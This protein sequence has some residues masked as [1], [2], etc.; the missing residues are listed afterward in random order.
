MVLGETWPLE[1]M[2][3]FILILIRVAAILY[4]MPVLGTRNI[5]A[6]SKI[7]LSMMISFLLIPLVKID[8]QSFPQE[9]LYF[10][11]FL[12]KEIILGMVLGISIKFIFA[13]VQAGG[14]LAGFNMGFTMAQI[15]DPQSGFQE[16][17]LTQL[18][19][20]LSMLIFLAIDGHHWFIR[21][22][23][24]SLEIVPPGGFFLREPLGEHLV[25]LSGGIL[26]IAVKIAAP[27]LVA[28]FLVQMGLGILAKAAPQINIMMTS[29]PLIIAAGLLIL[30]LSTLL[31][32]G[33][34]KEIFMDG[35]RGLIFGILPMVK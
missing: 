18:Y 35:S 26:I 13:G 31:I 3:I 15:V 12:L 33:Y 28:L 32:M 23:S 7:G 9:P 11:L 24:Y 5:P 19:F 14:H 4:F 2:K 20:L 1:Q 34:L 29:F 27:I 6:I 10:V 21:A 17:V 8:S 22:L 30:A 16:T 25:R